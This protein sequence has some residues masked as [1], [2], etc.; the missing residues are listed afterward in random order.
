MYS[1]YIFDF[2]YTLVN[3]E[4]AIVMC[5][6]M[7]LRDEGFPP[8]DRESICRT[9]GKSMK[10]SMS[11]LT[12]VTDTERIAELCHLYKIR[13][14]DIYMTPN[15]H[16][17]PQTRPMLERLKQKGA[18]TAIVS[19]K[20]RRRINQTI[21]R[22]HLE[23]LIDYVVGSEDVHTPKPSPEGLFYVIDH[24][25]LSKKDILYIGDHTIDAETAV[26]AGVD[27]AAVTTGTTTAEEFTVYPCIQIMSSLD[28]LM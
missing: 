5:F 18:R 15:T 17:Y 10:E 19:T 9:I 4:Q 6:E 27:F 26:Q 16:L 11:I 25:H 7:L 8:A 23:S 3:S 24:F 12:G 21:A 22:E 13:Y 1:T 20:T 2:D 28:E 14:S